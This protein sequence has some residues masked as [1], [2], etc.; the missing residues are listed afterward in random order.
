MLSAHTSP[1]QLRESGIP[2][3]THDRATAQAAQLASEPTR[4]GRRKL[5]SG[6]FFVEPDYVALGPRGEVAN[7]SG[8]VSYWGLKQTIV[9]ATSLSAND[10]RRTLD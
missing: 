5:F 2:N 1:L 7:A 9:I 6:G 4:S 10:P 8:H 3:L